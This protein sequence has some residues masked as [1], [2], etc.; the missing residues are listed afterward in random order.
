MMRTRMT[1]LALA[2]VALSV[3]SA[4]W[5]LSDE[6]TDVVVPVVRSAPVIA[7][8]GWKCPDTTQ[9]PGG[10][11]SGTDEPVAFAD[12]PRNASGQTYG[13]T[14]PGP[15]ENQP[16]LISAM[17]KDE[18]ER[19]VEGYAARCDL[20]SMDADGRRV[21]LYAS[22]GQAMLGSLKSP[23]NVHPGPNQVPTRD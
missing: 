10:P 11:S 1:P 9:V 14:V 13:Q 2:A 18:A 19:W 6:R 20:F 21:P 5:A 15:L 23:D 16:D 17:G 4:A 8:T 7:P 22:D 3:G 12:F